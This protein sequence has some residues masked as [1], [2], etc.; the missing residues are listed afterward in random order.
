MVGSTSVLEFR[1]QVKN[2]RLSRFEQLINNFNMDMAAAFTGV[3][4]H[5]EPNQEVRSD[6][7]TLFVGKPNS[8]VQVNSSGSVSSHVLN[9]LAQRGLSVANRD[10]NRLRSYNGSNHPAPRLIADLHAAITMNRVIERG[11][12]F[13]QSNPGSVYYIV[14]IGAKYAK[15]AGLYY[16]ALFEYSSRV[17]YIGVRPNTD[18]YD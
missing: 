11:R 6:S 3:Y 12:N 2:Q 14:D 4:N 18:T 5:N 15:H 13:L 1:K 7:R 8:N 17:C 9:Q 10:N 16:K